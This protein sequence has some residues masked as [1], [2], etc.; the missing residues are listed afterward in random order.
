MSRCN[1]L[2][3]AVGR[4]DEHVLAAESCA[5]GR[6][7]RPAIGDVLG[8]ARSANYCSS[9]FATT[10][11]QAIPILLDRWG[12][13]LSTKV[14][15]GEQ[16]VDNQIRRYWSVRVDPGIGSPCR[17]WDAERMLCSRNLFGAL[18]RGPRLR[19]AHATY[20]GRRPAVAMSRRIED[21]LATAGVTVADLSDVS[22]DSGVRRSAQQAA[23]VSGKLKLAA[24]DA[25]SLVACLD[26]QRSA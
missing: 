24:G 6:C 7:C 21:E 22:L 1:D 18:Q 26:A 23:H 4:A 9:T 16:I 19:E 5:D 14:R 17:G 3:A 8:R 13:R 25:C 10:A 15:E 20:N 12:G 2:R 11:L